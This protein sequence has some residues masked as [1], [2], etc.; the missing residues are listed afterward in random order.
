MNFEKLFGQQVFKE[1]DCNPFQSS[2]SLSIRSSCFICSGIYFFF[3]CSEQLFLCFTEFGGGSYLSNFEK[4][5]D[6]APLRAERALI[7]PSLI[8]QL[9]F[10]S[11]SL[12][13]GI[14]LRKTHL[15][16]P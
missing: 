14:Y 10:F 16:Q 6:A 3:L 2:S 5:R 15:F 8:L 12:L 13:R 9:F 11:A 1:Q 4:F 7:P